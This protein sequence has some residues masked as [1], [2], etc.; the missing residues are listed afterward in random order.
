MNNLIDVH[1]ITHNEPQWQLD[2]CLDSL[3]SEPINLRIFQGFDE[4]P[5]IQGRALG[6]S[7][8][9]A[10]YVSYVDPDDYIVP[11]AFT[12]LLTAIQS[13]DYDAAYGWEIVIIKGVQ[14]KILKVPHHAFVLR[15]GL[16]INYSS[17]W[18]VFA[19]PP[20]I[21]RSRIITVDEVLYYRDMGE[22]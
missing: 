4:W 12:K 7:K 15:R 5:P 6:Y 3:K 9:T 13:G 8:G 10:P 19:N 18:R 16:P 21:N 17:S 11:G 14:G 1:L 22:R 2:R 20:G